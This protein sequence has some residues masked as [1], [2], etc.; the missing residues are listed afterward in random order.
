MEPESA[1]EEVEER[2][3]DTADAMS[4]RISSLRDEL[5]STGTSLRDWVVRNPWKSVGGM[6]IGGVAVGALF[7]GGRRDGRPE[8]A[9]LLNR[10]TELLREE[11]DE[12]VA[13]GR[14]PA[15]ALEAVL[16]EGVPLVV[17]RSEEEE[18]SGSKAGF[19][20]AGIGFVLRIVFREVLREMV[21][22]MLE[23]AEGME[24][25]SEDLVE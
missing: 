10:Y 1:Q 4:D 11:M 16:Q 6:L 25:I 22:S 23:D 15:E 3:R 9:E 13:A 7:G 21:Y 24:D 19:I 8:H 18:S 2:L 14:S 5:S 17:L 20:G 12:A